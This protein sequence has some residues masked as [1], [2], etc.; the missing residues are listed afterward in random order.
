MLYIFIACSFIKK[1]P[2][3]V[4]VLI[5]YNSLIIICIIL[6]SLKSFIAFRFSQV[7]NTKFQL[8]LLIPI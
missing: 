4:Y 1:F 2:L 5:M 8:N 3:F 7:P 6:I